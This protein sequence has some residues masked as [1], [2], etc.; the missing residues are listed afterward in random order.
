VSTGAPR[1]A[2][3]AWGVAPDPVLVRRSW[4]EVFRCTRGAE[5]LYVRVTFP[6]HR[7]RAELVA[8]VDWMRSLHAAGVPV[9][10]PLPSLGGAYVEEVEHGGRPAFAI[11]LGAAPGHPGRKPQDYTPAV[12]EAWAALLAALHGHARHYRPPGPERR[13]SWRTD[14]VLALALAARDEESRF[15]QGPLR[16]L[17]SWME[18]LPTGPETFGLTHADLHP[19]NLAVDSGPGL[20]G[21]RLTA[22]DFDDSCEHFFV[23]DLAVGVTSL[24][25]A[26]WEYP[27]AV[28]G[29]A[30]EAAFLTAYARAAAGDPVATPVG[31]APIERF[32]HYRI[33]L[34]ACWAGRARELGELDA[35]MDAW[36]RRSV[37]WWAQQLAS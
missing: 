33:A 12:V 29:P 6:D 25:K 20:A 15:A 23:H 31:R 8:E 18:G 9:A 26:A 7:P 22:F 34:S 13:P 10:R 14:R 35:D 17:V 1:D 30:L 24:R 36:F 21:P 11:A 19:G 37:P 32:V 2:F 4:N 16:D 28:D 5:T 3:S 27:G